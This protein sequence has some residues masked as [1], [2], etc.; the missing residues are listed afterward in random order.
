MNKINLIS[1]YPSFA[2]AYEIGLLGNFSLNICVDTSNAEYDYI[3]MF[4][5]AKLLKRKYPLF[6]SNG[7]IYFEIN[8]LD[9]DKIITSNKCET[10]ID[11]T[12]RVKE[13]QSNIKPLFEFNPTNTELLKSFYNK[14]KV[15]VQDFQETLKIAEVIAQ[16]EGTPTVELSYIAEACL[17]KSLASESYLRA[18]IDYKPNYTII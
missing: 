7:I 10:I 12:N 15:S 13:K 2:R 1:C 4:E 8:K 17:Y 16:F 14:T 18:E 5:N 11:I 6:G 9:Y 3:T